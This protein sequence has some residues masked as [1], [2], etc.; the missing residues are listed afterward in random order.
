MDKTTYDQ[1]RA[2]HP[3]LPE[4]AVLEAEFEI[5]LIDAKDPTLLAIKHRIKDVFHPVTHYLGGVLQPDSGS[6]AEIYEYRMYTDKDKEHILNIYKRCMVLDKEMFICEMEN[7]AKKGVACI[8]KC[9]A[10][11]KDI[12]AQLIPLITRLKEH[13]QSCTM[14]EETHTYLG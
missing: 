14:V 9:L 7:E 2:K 3:Q 13:W 6:F 11:W 4:Y 1:L 12:K 8:N 5:S 10:E